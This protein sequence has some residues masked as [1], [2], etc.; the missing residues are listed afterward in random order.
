MRTSAD[1]FAQSVGGERDGIRTGHANRIET[2]RTG[3]PG[4]RRFKR[5]G[6]QKSRLA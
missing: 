3:G 5:V 4:E 6:R 1:E 2:E